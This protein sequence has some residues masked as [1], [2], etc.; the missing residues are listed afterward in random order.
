MVKL[1]AIWVKFLVKFPQKFC[2]RGESF[3]DFLYLI[4]RRVFIAL[5]DNRKG[6]NDMYD[7]VRRDGQADTTR[8]G[9]EKSM[10]KRII[11]VLLLCCM[12]L[13]LL[14]TTTFANNGGEKAI[15]I[16]TSGISDYDSTNSSYDYIH[17]GTWNNSTVKWRVLDT[18]TNMANAQQGD[19]FFLLSD[20][21]L[22]TEEYGSVEFDY[23]TP[24]T[25]DW[26]GSR[27]QDW[28]N[29]FYTGISALRSKK[30]FCQPAKVMLYNCCRCL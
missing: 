18:K 23:T 3:F 27:A 15:Q 2:V 21:L 20:V 7:T 12:V 25:N 24:Y 10:K 11:S 4:N 5:P 14:P 16:G 8:T 9:G 26:K 28:C 6:S 30:L 29:D 13:G 1:A 22:G 17:F 19:G